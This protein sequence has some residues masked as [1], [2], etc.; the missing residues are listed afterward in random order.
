MTVIQITCENCGAKYKLPE[1]F[2]GSQA[3]CQKCG[4]VIDVAKQRD[5]AASGEDAA[6][7]AAAKPAVD[8]SKGRGAAARKATGG[9]SGAKAAG[10]RQGRAGRG[11]TALDDDG[12]E[13]RPRRGGR[14]KKKDNTAM[15]ISVAGGALLLIAGAFFLFMGDDEKTGEEQANTEAA[16][17]AQDGATTDPKAGDA[18]QAGAAQAGAAE[19]GGADAGQSADAKLDALVAMVKEQ[20]SKL[21][22]DEAAI[23]EDE[24]KKMLKEQLEAQGVDLDK[25]PDA[26][27]QTIA[28]G[29]SAALGGDAASGAAAAAP[30]PADAPAPDAVPMPDGP[31]EPW[32]K[33]KNPAQT[34]ADVL[35]A[36]ELYGDVQWPESIDAKVKA[37]LQ[38]KAED[39]DVNGG[40]RHIR[41]KNAL[42]EAGYPA[43]FAILERLHGLDYRNAEDA[44]FGFELNKV[45][46]DITG[47][48]NA[49]YSAVQA[50]EEVHP[51]KAQWNTKTVNAWMVTF[52]KWPDEAAFTK[53]KK[54]R[55]KSK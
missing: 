35:S 6:P 5:A 46:E 27:M 10:E 34:M 44:A 38:G 24:V 28:A 20:A 37:E 41:A 2:K 23:S 11:R 16:S 53:A 19:G 3:K 9:A 4:S 49:R 36:A 33:Q 40:I 43:L 25:L 7:A 21:G 31:K 26:M 48:L 42:A 50:G 18:S 54:E 8:R 15:I 13:E 1:T 52:A 45:I 30:E 17:K 12:G 14:E 39:L 55:A 22:V 51:A 29:L 32:M 47:G